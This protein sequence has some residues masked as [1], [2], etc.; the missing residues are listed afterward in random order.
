MMPRNRLLPRLLMLILPVLLLTS[1]AAKSPSYNVVPEIPP[2]P[3][4]AKQ[5]VTPSVCLPSC[6]ANLTTA[7]ERWLGTLTPAE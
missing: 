3:A 7:R 5:P 1:C 6:S 4:E 2:L